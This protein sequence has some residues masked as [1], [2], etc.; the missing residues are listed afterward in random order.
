MKLATSTG[1]FSLYKSLVPDKVRLFKDT[2]FKYINLEQS[3]TALPELFSENDDDWKRV[4]DACGE[5]A[6]YAGVKYVVSH[7]PCVN[8]F[9][10]LD[11]ETYKT[12]TRAVRRSIQVC[13][14]LG[15]SRIVVH[16]GTNE[17]FHE[18]EFYTQNKRFY[19][20][21]FDLMEKYGVT[22]MT[23]NFTSENYPVLSTGEDMMRM[24]D[25]VSHPLFGACWDTAHC[26]LNSKAK[27][28]GQYAN[29][30]ALGDKLKGLHVSDNFGNRGEHHHTWPFAGTIN[31]DSIMQALIDIKYDGY[32]TFEA[33]YT[34]LHH[35]NNP[36]KRKSWEYNKTEVTKL[37]DPSVALKQKAVD[38][39]Y[40]IGQYLLETY[41][42]FE[43]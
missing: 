32:F 23:E 22:V 33:S 43:E 16:A 19:S 36:H 39:L 31:F 2:K 24:I 41:N 15:I 6:T 30:V 4:A 29:L 5:A 17:G 9:A 26:N 1:D 20:D 8:P 18:D 12:A 21:L 35:G 11:D 42:C 27:E 38:L 25:A 14:S 28:I 40:D 10:K 37:L 3:G 13:G 7:A 34:L